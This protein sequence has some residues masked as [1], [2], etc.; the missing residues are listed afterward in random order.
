LYR[1][2]TNEVWQEY[3]DKSDRQGFSF[4]QVILSGCQNVDSGIGCYAGSADSY[5]TF[6]KFFDHV[7]KEYHKFEPGKDTHEANLNVSELTVRHLTEQEASLVISSRIRV[8][9]NL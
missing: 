2:L 7:I 9:R 4:K 6:A 5:I 3:K 1:A 8:S